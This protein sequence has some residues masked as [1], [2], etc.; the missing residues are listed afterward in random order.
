[1]LAPAEQQA[2]T[3]TL[4]G[5]SSKKRTSKFHKFDKHYKHLKSLTEKRTCQV[6]WNRRKT[7]PEKVTLVYGQLIRHPC[8]AII[9]GKNV[10]HIVEHNQLAEIGKPFLPPLESKPTSIVYEK[11]T[12][13]L[14]E[15]KEYIL[16]Q[17]AYETTDRVTVYK[18]DDPSKK[19]KFFLKSLI[20]FKPT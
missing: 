13:V 2:K 18:A 10:R 19:Q 17:N 11:G 7:G 3:G 15:G 4:H 5:V 12:R 6:M 16:D 20:E 14:K 8:L 9:D 1:M